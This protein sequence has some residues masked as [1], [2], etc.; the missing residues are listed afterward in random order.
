MVCFV[1]HKSDYNACEESG[2]VG[3]ECHLIGTS[4]RWV[5]F[6]H[7][8]RFIEGAANDA[9]DDV[10]YTRFDVLEVFMVLDGEDYFY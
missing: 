3:N 5:S 7:H 9:N 4:N 8:K 10:G 6:E 1:E 2:H